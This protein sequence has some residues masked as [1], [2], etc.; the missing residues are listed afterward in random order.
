MVIRGRVLACMSATSAIALVGCSGSAAGGSAAT[1]APRSAATLVSQMK[2]AVGAATSM[3]LVGQLPESGRP[4]TLNLGVLRAG[5]LAG[6]ISGNGAALHLVGSRGKVYVQATP[7]FL[8]E[9]KAPAA[10]C[11]VMCGKYVQLSGQQ[12]SELAG[13]LSMTSLTRSLIAGLPK[14]RQGGTTTVSGRAAVV[15]HGADG[16]TLDV[17]A[18]GTPYPLRVVATPGRHEA[19]VFSRWDT[20]PTPAAP[21]DGEVINLS[22][23]KA[24]SG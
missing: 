1:A 2:A 14:F 24:G 18:R 19:V 21:K 23:L 5:D 17:A 16:S 20:V 10:V 12:A 15:L 11:S 4:V 9:L 6:T 3:H 22:Q 8:R 13:S 7:A